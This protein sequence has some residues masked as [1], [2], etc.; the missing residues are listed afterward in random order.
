MNDKNHRSKCKV[1]KML[2]E[3]NSNDKFYTKVKK[4]DEMG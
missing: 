4:M 3:D 1:L 2:K